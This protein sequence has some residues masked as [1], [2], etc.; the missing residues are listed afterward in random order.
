MISTAADPITLELVQ[1]SLQ[2][3]IDEMVASLWAGIAAVR[4]GERGLLELVDK[5]G[6]ETFTTALE[7]FMDDGER[8]ALRVLEGLP[9]GYGTT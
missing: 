9:K 8:V 6:L 5:Y 2:S 1:S 4:I 7:Q 3:I